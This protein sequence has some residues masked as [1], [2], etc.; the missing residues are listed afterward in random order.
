MIDE[1]SQVIYN[2]KTLEVSTWLS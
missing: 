1:L 2:G